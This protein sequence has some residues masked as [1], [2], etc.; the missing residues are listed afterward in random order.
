MK[1]RA[2]GGRGAAPW[3]LAVAALLAAAAIADGCSSS[4]GRKKRKPGGGGKGSPTDYVFDY[5]TYLGGSGFDRAQGI[6]VDDQGNVYLGGNVHGP[7]FPT[8]PGAF[9]TTKNG[10][11]SGNDSGDGFV[12]KFSPTGAL[13]WSTLLGGTLR[14]QVYRLMVDDQGFVYA[15][16]STGSSDLLFEAP[17]GTPGFDQ[18]FNGPTQTNGYGDIFAVKLTPDGSGVVWWTYI[19]GTGRDTSRGSM[20]LT[21]DGRIYVTGVSASDDF[22]IPPGMNPPPFQPARAGGEDVIVFRLSADGTAI[23]KATY[24]GGTGSDAGL[25]GLDIASNGDVIVGGG[26]NSS[27]FPGTTPAAYGGG[28]GSNNWWAGDGYVSRLDGDLSQLV[29]SIYIGGPGDD[30][31]IHNQGMAVD[32]RD[33]AHLLVYT[34]S[35]ALPTTTGASFGGTRDAYIAR[36]AADG[37]QV[38]AATYVGGSDDDYPAGIAVDD[39]SGH[40]FFSGMTRSP[41]YPTTATAAGSALQGTR[42]VMVTV[43]KP[44][45]S[46]LYSTIFEG[47]PQEPEDQRGRGGWVGPDG[48]YHASGIVTAD[49]PV[50]PGAWQTTPGGGGDAFYVKMLPK[51]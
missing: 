21:S 2:R 5:A 14:D 4:G 38:E 3:L 37:S 41:D 25:A 17:P 15:V 47:A 39:A 46:I 26:T 16:G 20:D 35:P 24:L 31:G 30:Y 50:T 8:T 29:W 10:P 23:E 28:S 40:V 36:V 22:P 45:L 44:D 48:S 7:G 27:D 34:D 42:D 18:T 6:F 1:H 32:A 19:G 51:P 49:F 9:D 43:L 33:R 13:I 12:A 11:T